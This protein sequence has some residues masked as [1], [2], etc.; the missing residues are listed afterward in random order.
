MWKDLSTEES[1]NQTHIDPSEKEVGAPYVVSISSK[2]ELGFANSSAVSSS[3]VLHV[4][5]FRQVSDVK[6]E[7]LT[8]GV[9][10]IS[11]LSR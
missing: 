8:Y 5:D 3:S 2:F 4:E 11:E 10:C 1:D 7:P 9:H 6:V